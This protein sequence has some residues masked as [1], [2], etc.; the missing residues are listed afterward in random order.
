[1]VKLVPLLSQDK[2]VQPVLGSLIDLEVFIQILNRY[3]R[4]S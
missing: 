1:M 3:A 4:H 2:F